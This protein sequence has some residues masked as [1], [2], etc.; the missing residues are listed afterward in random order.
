MPRQEI[1]FK[2]QF[3][4]Q[5][6]FDLD[7]GLD[8]LGHTSAR[9]SLAP[10]LCHQL[11]Q[12]AAGRLTGGHDFL[13]VLVAQFVQAELAMRRHIQRGGQRVRW[14]AL[15]QAHA[16]AQVPFG[17]PCQRQ[18]AL[19]QG[20]AKAR[21]GEHILQRLARA[22]VHVHVARGHQR[23]ARGG[24]DLAQGTQPVGVVQAVVLG[25][26]EPAALLE[27]LLQPPR[28]V[29]DDLAWRGAFGHHQH[30]AV[31]QLPGR[32][33][34]PVKRCLAFALLGTPQPGDEL[35]EP[36]IAPSPA[37]QHDQTEG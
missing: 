27:M 31:C 16:V 8:F 18:A 14:V 2:A 30:Q 23:H 6:Q 7:L 10:A 26:G 3:F 29:L 24:A 35:A 28:L 20:Q 22:G 17:M 11:A 1:L 5:A 19:G 21:G 15:R 32:D 36:A 25:Q 34:A 37:C 33:V 12:M 9:V 4:D 13:G